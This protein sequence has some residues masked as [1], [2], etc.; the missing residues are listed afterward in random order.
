M[1]GGICYFN[2]TGNAGMAKGGSG[3]ALTGIITSL[4]ASGYQPEQAAILG[5]YLH[6]FA[7]DLAADVLS[8]EALWLVTSFNLYRLL[9]KN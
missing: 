1:P 5:V 9:L 4:L 2:S 8:K 7:A 3:D 6:G